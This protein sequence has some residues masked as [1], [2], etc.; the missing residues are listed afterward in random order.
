MTRTRQLWLKA[1]PYLNP[2]LPLD[3]AQKLRDGWP[4]NLTPDER[5]A[6]ADYEKRAHRFLR[7]L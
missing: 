2:A 4:D 5:Q 7:Y 3:E 6:L 1:H